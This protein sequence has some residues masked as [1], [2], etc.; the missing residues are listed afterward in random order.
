MLPLDSTWRRFGRRSFFSIIFFHV[1]VLI[2]ARIFFFTRPSM[3]LTSSNQI[4]HR[5][6]ASRW[7]S[8]FTT[9]AQDGPI[10]CFFLAWFCHT[11][12]QTQRGASR[13]RFFFPTRRALWERDV[14]RVCVCCLD[15]QAGRSCTA[16]PSRPRLSSPPLT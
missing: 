8:H 4:S 16:T 15:N 3:W 1:R 6:M 13:E 7:F 10:F 9:A 5:Q 12:R 2:E 14:V 11:P